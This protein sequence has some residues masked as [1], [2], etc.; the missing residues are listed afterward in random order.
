MS[1]WKFVFCTLILRSITG[2]NLRKIW[3]GGLHGLDDLT[4][5][6]PT[7]GALESLTWHFSMLFQIQA[8]Q[9]KQ[10]LTNWNCLYDHFSI[11]HV[12][13][14][15]NKTFFDLNKQEKIPEKISG[16]TRKTA[17]LVFTGKMSSVKYF[18]KHATINFETVRYV[19]FHTK[20]LFFTTSYLCYHIT[21]NFIRWM[22]KE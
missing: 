4:W 19:I 22:N 1:D 18:G 9:Y 17:N 8:Q 7:L 16:C 12:Q 10:Y 14:H 21:I 5:N 11:T 3:D 13:P 2:K 20:C 15:L 6:Y